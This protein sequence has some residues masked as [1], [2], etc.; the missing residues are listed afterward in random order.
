MIQSTL[1]QQDII[2]VIAKHGKAS[3]STIKEEIW[4]DLSI[5]SLN[6][7]LA[8]LVAENYLQKTGKGRATTYIV[9]PYYKLFALIEDAAYFDKEPDSRGAATTFNHN[10]LGTL[11]NIDILSEE[12]KSLLEDLKQ[13]Y[14]S[15]ISSL[16]PTLYKKELERL[17]I[18]L[19]WKSSQIEGNTYSLLETERLFREKEAA[20]DKTPEE[21]TMLLNHKDALNYILEY[22]KLAENLNIRV[23]EEIHSLIIK[24]L[25]SAKICASAL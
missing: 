16:P 10:L 5:P 19:S 1:R 24:G 11:A 23:L 12:E 7:E 2:K 20:K 22:K 15:N 8:A 13:E 18:E 14:Q 9:T 25:G 3:T 4:E 21:A 17:T 6:R